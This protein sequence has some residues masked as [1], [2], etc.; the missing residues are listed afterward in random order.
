MVGLL[1]KK[2]INFRR[3]QIMK[4][5]TWILALGLA[6]TLALSACT[7]E[8]PQSEDKSQSADKEEE[9]KPETDAKENGTGEQK[10]TDQEQQPEAEKKEEPQQ[11]ATDNK[12][13]TST[14][15]KQDTTQKPGQKPAQK[16][17]NGGSQNN[18]PSAPPANQ[19]P[20]PKPEPTPEPTP[21]SVAAADVV[22]DIISQYGTVSLGS[23]DDVVGTLYSGIDLSKIQSYSVK[24]SMMNVKCNEIAV[25]QVKDSA[26]LG[27]VQSALQQ[28]ASDVA[29]T[30]ETYLQDQYEIA[31]NAVVKTKGNYVCLIIDENADS[32]A[33]AFE[34]LVG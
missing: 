17:S 22:D 10:P 18:T 30:F 19:E 7:K 27:M 12:Q 9:S 28:R 20:T 25:F 2:Q 13:N 26:D 31:K 3:N 21:P 11:P 6:C 5:W 23:F 34:T 29:K 24:G 1:S 8:P 32:M 16:P 4:K 14:D 33:S 15:K